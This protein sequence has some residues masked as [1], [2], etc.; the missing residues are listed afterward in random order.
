MLMA[1][2]GRMFTA[3]EERKKAWKRKKAE[4]QGPTVRGREQP[5]STTRKSYAV[6]PAERRSSPKY[7]RTDFMRRYVSRVFFG[8]M[9]LK[10]PNIVENGGYA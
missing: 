2:N 7:T 3:A 10:R 9:R 8:C 5:R 1:K 4:E 6:H